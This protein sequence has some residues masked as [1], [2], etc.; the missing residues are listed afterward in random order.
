MK[1]LQNVI[2]GFKS[3]NLWIC[4][5][6]LLHFGIL[7]SYMCCQLHLE[8]LWWC[9]NP[10]LLSF[11]Q[12]Y[13][14]IYYIIIWVIWMHVKH[15]IIWLTVGWEMPDLSPMPCWNVPVVKNHSVVL[16]FPKVWQVSG[17]DQLK[18]H[19]ARHWKSGWKL[20]FSSDT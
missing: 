12:L 17:R 10:S 13:L 19:E 18:L 8:N 1:Y 15:I 16:G 2:Y 7:E 5:C 9:E 4:I 11:P 20:E 3:V 14:E 6:K